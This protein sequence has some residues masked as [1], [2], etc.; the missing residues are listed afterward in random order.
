[1]SHAG[2]LMYLARAATG[3]LC[4][5][6]ESRLG[7]LA[8]ACL[9][10]GLVAHFGGDHLRER[11][12]ERAERA[13]KWPLWLVWMCVAGVILVGAAAIEEVAKH[14]PGK[15]QQDYYDQQVQQKQREYLNEQIRPSVDEAT[16][17]YYE[18]NYP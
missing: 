14:G 2:L 4:M 10:I 3:P 13:R 9:G 6:M 11:A 18:N 5:S 15:V 16:R 17:S 8:V 12:V 7:I 1:V